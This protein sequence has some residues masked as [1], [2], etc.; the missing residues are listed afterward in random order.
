MIE[1]RTLL[2]KTDA[3]R[4]GCFILAPYSDA[5]SWAE[6]THDLS[7]RD[8]EQELALHGW[9]FSYLAGAIR[10]TAFGF[11]PEKRMASAL[12]KLSAIAQKQ[13]CNCLEIDQITVR[14]FLGAPY[15]TISAHSRNI[16]T[17]SSGRQ[18]RFA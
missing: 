17:A 5:K 14:S 11:S 1:A 8:L 4:P 6:V 3:P 13:Q 7:A 16:Q 9:T 15:L 10:A 2:M 18:I 12:Q